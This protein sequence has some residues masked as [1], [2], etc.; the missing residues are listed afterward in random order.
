MEDVSTVFEDML[1]LPQPDQADKGVQYERSKPI[2]PLTEDSAT[3]T[4]LLQICYPRTTLK[5]EIEAICGVYRAVKKYG[6]ERVE[7]D[8]LSLVKDMDS[9]YRL[10]AIASQCQFKKLMEAAAERTLKI[11]AT[12]PGPY[13]KE[14]EDISGGDLHRLLEYRRKHIAAVESLMKT[15]FVGRK[16]DLRSISRPKRFTCTYVWFACGIRDESCQ[17]GGEQLNCG[18]ASSQKIPKRWFED[19]FRSLRNALVE[20][21]SVDTLDDIDINDAASQALKCQVC[22]PEA[23]PDLKRFRD[24]VKSTLKE[25]FSVVSI[26]IDTT[27]D[28][29]VNLYPR[30][31]WSFYDFRV[32]DLGR[33]RWG[34]EVQRGREMG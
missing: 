34:E 2:I 31:S 24:N 8:L 7:E 1:S 13:Y 15:V 19:Y 30:S 26:D 21:P 11:A 12:S 3:L 4:V 25:E 33:K 5:I 28:F 17:E 23:Y 14:L 20:K 9:P 32:F 10:F 6:M 18:Q 16:L 27:N 22:R 29:S